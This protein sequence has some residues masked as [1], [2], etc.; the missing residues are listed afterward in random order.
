MDYIET[1]ERLTITIADSERKELA[2]LKAEDP[3]HFGTD[4]AMYDFLERLTC[5]SDLDW[6]NAEQTGDLTSAPMLGIF[7]ET[8]TEESGQFG[9]RHCGCWNDDG[10][11]V[12][13]PRFDPIIA[14]WGFMDYALRSPL[15][16]LL[17]KGEVTFV[18]SN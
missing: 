11:T 18:A 12:S 8:T 6:V 9:A 16:D 3:D 17:D 14:R 1:P 4:D 15:D 5:N 10:D 2:E 13:K 7:G